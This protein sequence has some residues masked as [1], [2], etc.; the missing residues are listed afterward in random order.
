MK[1]NRLIFYCLFALFHLG[2]FIF[3]IVLDNNSSLLFKMV[4]WVPSFKWITLFGL[5]L[6]I[7]D[8]LWARSAN[9]KSEAEKS[10]LNQELNMLKAKLF[11]LQEAA[12]STAASQSNSP[13][14]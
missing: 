6:F 7:T 14:P 2:A 8:V 10:T 4:G 5:V 11:D 1:K 12:K 9:K 13:K 3:T